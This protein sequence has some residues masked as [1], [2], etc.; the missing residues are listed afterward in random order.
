ML[1]SRALL[2]SLEIHTVR[3]VTSRTNLVLGTC[4]LLQFNHYGI[5]LVFQLSD[6]V[7]IIFHAYKMFYTISIN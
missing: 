5:K 4:N 3:G 7:H 6:I 2:A 1:S